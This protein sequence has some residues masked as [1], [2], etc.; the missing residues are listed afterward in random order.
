MTLSTPFFPHL[1]VL[2]FCLN[3]GQIF[4]FRKEASVFGTISGYQFAR[5]A[6]PCLLLHAELNL[7][8]EMW[9]KVSV[10]KQGLVPEHDVVNSIVFPD[11]F[12]AVRA[13][14]WDVGAR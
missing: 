3:C 13:L 7:E 11:R 1:G 4:P 6:H 14:D 8:N 2:S 9:V 12:Q 10:V 5:D